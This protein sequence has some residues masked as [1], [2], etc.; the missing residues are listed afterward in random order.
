MPEIDILD[1][2]RSLLSRPQLVIHDAPT[3]DDQEAEHGAA[4]HINLSLLLLLLDHRRE[5]LL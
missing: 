1:H 4:C 2:A 5:L 3:P